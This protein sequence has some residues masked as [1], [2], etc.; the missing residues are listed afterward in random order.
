LWQSPLAAYGYS[1][2]SDTQGTLLQTEVLAPDAERAMRGLADV[3]RST[4]WPADMV[5]DALQVE[6]TQRHSE[7]WTP[8]LVARAQVMARLFEGDEALGVTD[9]ARRMFLESLSPDDVSNL[10]HSLYATSHSALCVVGDEATTES[11][12]ALAATLPLATTSPDPLG[13]MLQPTPVANAVYVV[14]MAS[15]QAHV[16]AA[17]VAPLASEA[18]FP[19]MWLLDRLAGRMFTSALNLDLREG[20][21]LSYN[22]RTSMVTSLAFGAWLFEAA[23]DGDRVSDAISA[24]HA[25]FQRM[26][27]D[28]SADEFERSKAM[29]VAELEARLETNGGL[30]SWLAWRFQQGLET[31]DVASFLQRVRGLALSTVQEFAR[32]HIPEHLGPVVIVGAGQY[33]RAQLQWTD[34]RATN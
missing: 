22:P 13:A 27:I 20:R 28:I 12:V 19:A 21:A 3:F 8:G 18:D 33:I 17:F 23:V 10:A 6:A 26:T 24:L 29:A 16:A 4:R 14:D 32:Y 11:L 34:Y 1:G 25:Q 15:P 30:L 2:E 31:T 5:T 7:A 9:D